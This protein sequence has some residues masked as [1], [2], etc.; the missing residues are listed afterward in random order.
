M[1]RLEGPSSRSS[2]ERLVERVG[3]ADLYG[4][5]FVLEDVLLGFVPAWR[6]VD[7]FGTL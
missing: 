3:E 2:N 1:S 7:V 4:A 5:P 6:G